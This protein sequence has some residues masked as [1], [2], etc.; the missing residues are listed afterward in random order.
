MPTG[1]LIADADDPF[2]GDVD[3]DHLQNAASEFITSLHAIGASIAK[4]QGFFDRGPHVLVDLFDFRVQA[5]I[6]P[7][8]Q[9]RQVECLGFLGDILWILAAG[10]RS[11]IP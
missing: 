4:I 6:E 5:R 9:A 2:G 11:A 1:H 7:I 10:K 8:E 3:F